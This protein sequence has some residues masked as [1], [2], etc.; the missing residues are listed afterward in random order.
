L[1]AGAAEVY[2]VSCSSA[3]NCAAGG[4][5]TD[6]SSAAQA[7][8]VDETNGSWGTPTEVAASLNTEGNA[9]VNSVSCS[10][11]GNCA[12]GGQYKDGSGHYQ[13]FVVDEANGIWGTATEVAASLNAGGNA[14]V[15][16]VSCSSDGNCAAGGQYKDASND[17]QAFVAGSVLTATVAVSNNS[18]SAGGTLVFTA[19]VSGSGESTP[20]GTPTWTLT[21]PGG[22]SA[23]C[24]TT[25][26]PSGSTNV[27]TYTC[28]VDDA[29][30]GT[31]QASFSYPGNVAYAP[32]SGI[33]TSAVVSA[34]TTT[35]TPPPTTELPKPTPRNDILKPGVRSTTVIVRLTA[36]NAGTKLVVYESEP[37]GKLKVSSVK[38]AADQDASFATGTLPVGVTTIRFY[39][40][41]TKKKKDGK[42][43]K[44]LVWTVKVHVS[45][46]TPKNKK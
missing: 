15:N 23:G 14:E 35:T 21:A 13:A 27:A 1:N 40:T 26:G 46:K 22:G 4:Y 38:L 30:A 16:S 24:S 32:A 2:S 17:V 28:A 31:Y 5:Y 20:T 34:S 12:A 8:V 44:K 33:D 19:T 29:A 36:L 37:G 3:G 6:G 43:T 11:V 18:V 25:S 42:S 41:V 10:S 39:E 9:T 45:K 7:F